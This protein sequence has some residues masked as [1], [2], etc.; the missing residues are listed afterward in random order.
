MADPRPKFHCQECGALVAPTEF[1]SYDSCLLV[2]IGNERDLSPSDHA[3]LIQ[4]AVE[5]L[6]QRVREKKVG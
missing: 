6:T 2:K 5:A 1:H 4:R 3:Y